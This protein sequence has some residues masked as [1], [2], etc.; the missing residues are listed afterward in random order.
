MPLSLV[1]QNTQLKLDAFQQAG[2]NVYSY[3]MLIKTNTAANTD[4]DASVIVS[5]LLAS[6]DFA[7]SIQAADAGVV[8]AY[9]R[10]TGQTAAQVQADASATL[11]ALNVVRSA[12]RSVVPVDPSL[13]SAGTR[14]LRLQTVDTTTGAVS[15]VTVPWSSMSALVTAIDAWVATIQ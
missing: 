5:A 12:I 11:S 2:R 13:P 15:P 4:T 1:P 3:L 9:R 14:Y 8:A 6:N 10:E 7:A